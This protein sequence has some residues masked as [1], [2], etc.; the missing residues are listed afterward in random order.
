MYKHQDFEPFRKNSII[1]ETNILVDNQK[2]DS[3]KSVNEK[4]Y[5]RVLEIIR[6]K[7]G[8]NAI[9]KNSEQERKEEIKKEVDW[10]KKDM[11]W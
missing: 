8:Y 4:D 5:Q 9:S 7:Y 3:F 2:T 6:R 11:E 1:V 10:L